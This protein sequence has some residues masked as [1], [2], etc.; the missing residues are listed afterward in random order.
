MAKRPRH[1][2]KDIEAAVRHAEDAGWRWR[3]GKGHCWGRLL[4]PKHDRD[5]CQHSVNGTPAKP[6]AAAKDI[7]RAIERCDHGE[8]NDEGL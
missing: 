1:P 4:C 2:D 7:K 8:Q 5:G 6:H 3:R